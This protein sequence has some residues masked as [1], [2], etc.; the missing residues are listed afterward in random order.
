MT[1]NDEFLVESEIDIQPSDLP[2]ASLAILLPLAD[3]D[4][5]V[6]YDSEKQ[7]IR[8]PSDLPTDGKSIRYVPDSVAEKMGF[9]KA[10]D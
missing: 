5:S 6:E 9:P 4:G 10:D 8:V 2:I 1:E 3:M 7:V